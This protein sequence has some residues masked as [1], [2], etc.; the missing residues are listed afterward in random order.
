MK[1]KITSALNNFLRK[2]GFEF[3]RYPEGDMLRR[4]RLL[5]YFNI[6]KVFDIGA[7]S[8][9]YA[10]FMRQI[11]FK[12]KIVSFEPLREAYDE[13]KRKASRDKDWS[14]LNIAVGD[15][16]GEALINVAG[17]S[18]SSSILDMLPS[19][20]KSAPDSLYI[21]KEKIAIKKFDSI[22]R[23]YYEDGD[24][25]FLKIDTQ[26]YEKNVIKG[27]EKTIPMVRG[28]QL[29]MSLIPLYKE[30]MLF[31]DMIKYMKDA[32]F[33][34]WALENGFTNNESGKLLQV[35]GIFFRRSGQ[36]ERA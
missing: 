31:D 20:V 27:A 4:I 24:N 32:G 16:D 34:L 3:K 17:N 28:I 10:V 8:G 30:E 19:H 26:G 25:I 15:Y 18:Y 7:N 33:D 11:G 22:I 14:V 23:D 12:G 2:N 35:D 1:V 13:L 6:N 36:K 29:E 5:K 21:R 9:Q